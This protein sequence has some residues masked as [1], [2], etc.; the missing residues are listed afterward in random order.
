MDLTTDQRAALDLAYGELSAGKSF[1]L[2]GYAGTGKTYTVN[3]LPLNF[4]AVVAPTHAALSLLRGR[5]PD[6]PA[7][8]LAQ[9][10][11]KAPAGVSLGCL[12]KE[13]AKHTQVPFPLT[14]E[15]YEGTSVV[16]SDLETFAAEG[17]HPSE[18]KKAIASVI[19]KISEPGFAQ[20][21]DKAPVKRASMLV[22]VDEAGMI[23]SLDL[24]HLYESAH[25]YLFL[26]DS[27][28][29]PP[30]EKDR[31]DGDVSPVFGSTR[32]TYQL[33]E[34]LRAENPTVVTACRQARQAIDQAIA[35]DKAAQW[36]AGLPRVKD[37]YA[38]LAG[39]S[40]L[41]AATNA[42]VEAANEGMVDYL[43]SQG[44][45]EREYQGGY[46]EGDTLIAY[47]NY[48]TGEQVWH[49]N[50][51]RF[52]LVCMVKQDEPFYGIPLWRAKVKSLDRAG[53]WF[54]V[55]L[56]DLEEG[57]PAL[58]R[59]ATELYYSKGRGS[60]SKPSPR[61]TQL[62]D[63]AWGSTEWATSH[64]LSR[65]LNTEILEPDD[66]YNGR[67]AGR[68][69]VWD[70]RPTWAMTIHKGQGQGFKS[71]VVASK[72]LN[73]WKRHHPIDAARMAYTA[74]SRARE[75]VWVLG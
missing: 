49:T 14:G 53:V 27:G 21:N 34:E 20:A 16:V 57:Y 29:V 3:Q 23:G 7:F 71:V 15:D 62:L 64:G 72:G 50:A 66:R 4:G 42:E 69:R 8:T 26:G 74:V 24:A 39:G 22:L 63:R 33:T 32:K 61:L 44:Q 59:E 45:S 48:R 58:M 18:V 67:G 52:Q 28:Q 10:L 1:V 38:F 46:A 30:I 31:K 17:N 13:W 51:E 41:L 11:G 37:P 68:V 75:E 25:T 70:L 2:A 43:I 12:R 65:W 35:G 55:V 6:T 56:P 9:F 60:K 73:Q 40:V 54:E 36:A 5:F 47:S 19:E